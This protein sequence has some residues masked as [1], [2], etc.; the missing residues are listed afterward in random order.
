[1]STD[2][3]NT[4]ANKRG[5]PTEYKPEFADELIEYFSVKP[6]EYKNLPRIVNGE[7]MLV[8][9]ETAAD[10]PTMAGFAVKLGVC[11]DTIHEWTKKHPEFSDA[12][13]MAKEYQENFWTINGHKGLIN[14]KF[15]ELTSVN[16]L[17]WRKQHSDDADK[18]II[19]NNV[20]NLSDEDLDAL[21]EQKAKKVL[22]ESE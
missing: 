19:N 22:G 16:I 15:A 1:M 17:N 11:R 5:R 14:S 6:Y 18:T 2:D 9:I 3:E 13:K 8:P 20:N 4:P 12:Y 10:T 21:I 7:I